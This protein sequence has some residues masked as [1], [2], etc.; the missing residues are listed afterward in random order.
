MDWW[1]LVHGDS[2]GVVCGALAYAALGGGRIYFTHP[3]GL[4]EDLRV[5]E[6]G[7]NV[8]IADVALTGKFVEAVIERLRLLASRGQV[9]YIDHHPLPEGLNPRVVPGTFI[10]RL[11][12]SASELTYMYFRDR[13]PVEGERLALLG[14]IGDYLD[15]T[16]W[17]REALKDWD[18]R[19]IYFE[20]GVLAQG[21]EGSR[22]M[23]D[24][25]R[26]VVKHLAEWRLPSTL[27][28]LLVR[29]LV[30]SVNEEEMRIY[31]KKNLHILRSVAY[32]IDP[33]GSVP[34]AATYARASAGK[35]VG[36]AVERRKGLAI[37]SLRTN[38]PKV[39]LHKILAQLAGRLGGT[40]GGHPHAAGARVPLG[41]LEEFLEMLDEEVTRL[42][43][44]K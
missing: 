40:G 2:D 10:H 33:P 42:T 41:S 24:F 4:A 37:M 20:A 30:E 39:D 43:S 7:S 26:H 38:H 34:R 17:V 27:G 25:K 9:V 23:H 8:L 6:P 36:V 12:A 28:E 44:S 35:P 29:A 18:K 21:L 31:V 22:R 32:V 1:L 14:A 13:L 3:A 11:E 19:A 5:V 15:E 16:P